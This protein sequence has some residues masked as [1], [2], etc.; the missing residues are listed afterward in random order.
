M[1]TLKFVMTT[2]FY[3]PYHIGG[4]AMHVYNLSNELADLGHEVHVIHSIDSYYWQH[5]KE[6]IDE[7]LNHDNIIKHSI[8]SP[9]GKLSPL[10]SYVFGK[11]YFSSNIICNIINEVKPDVL[12]HHNIAG[13]DPR[14]LG[15]KAPTVLYTA[16]D[17]WLVCQMGILN[18]YDHKYCSS[19]SNCVMCSIMSN[20]P[21]QIWRYS[22][23]LSKHLNNI[24]AII[25]P[26][27]FLMNKLQDFGLRG[28]FVTIPNF[29]PKPSETGIP[30][31]G[32]SYFLFV[33]VLEEHK[34][35][36]NLLKSFLSL[37]DKIDAN[38]LIVG[39]GSLQEDIKK[40]VSI[41]KCEN[42]IIITGRIDD[43]DLLANL[44]RNALAVFI[45]S[46]CPENC[47][48]VALEALSNGT[49]IFGESIGGLKEILDECA[50]EIPIYNN[51]S[52]NMERLMYNFNKKHYPTN[53]LISIYEKCYSPSS[54]LNKYLKLIKK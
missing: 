27:N 54:F 10:L 2:T 35:V 43:L 24:D 48:L 22:N 25:T 17:Y 13:F 6:P 50:K 15:I 28:N 4:D 32:F 19:R 1:E 16:H 26:S 45:P 9:I 53:L 12:H 20:R 34:G 38:L 41:N 14:I 31:Y 42:R 30:L 33:G 44:Y 51:N 7:Y 5:N 36:L 37:K 23:I 11:S 40:I 52:F 8:R 29:V 39:N 18:K 21:P 47:P 49:P 3:P 46:N